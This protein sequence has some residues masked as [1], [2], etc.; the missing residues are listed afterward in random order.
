MK[1]FLKRVYRKVHRI[2]SKLFKEKSEQKKW[3]ED[4]YNMP[5]L[6]W[7]VEQPEPWIVELA[8]QDKIVGNVADFG[9]GPGR[10]ALWLAAQK[11][12][13]VGMDISTRAIRRAKQ[14]ARA[15]KLKV[16][17]IQADMQMFLKF[18]NYF[19]TVIDI[20]CYHSIPEKQKY[21]SNLYRMTT[22]NATIYLRAHHI[23]K[24]RDGKQKHNISEEQIRNDFAYPQWEI[25][26]LVE[27][28]VPL[29][30][31]EGGKADAWFVTI[32]KK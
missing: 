30:T 11:F 16:K 7:D 6:P 19:D 22:E 25:I 1:T 32:K 14:K 29:L 5:I 31:Q 23:L 4:K 18:D 27:S 28:E 2:T 13:I 20:G 24:Y 9:C 8:E 21:I 10:N 3:W 17:F 26:S 15:K 12:D